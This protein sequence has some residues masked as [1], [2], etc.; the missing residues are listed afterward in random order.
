MS[1][2][3]NPEGAPQKGEDRK[4]DQPASAAV[5]SPIPDPV[6]PRRRI[7]RRQDPDYDADQ[8][9]YTLTSAEPGGIHGADSYATG[10]DPNPKFAEWQVSAL[11]LLAALGTIGFCVGYFAIG[12]HDR[13]G[14]PSNW[15]LGGGLAL[16]LT[17][18]G[19]G[20]ILWAKKL[21]PHEQAIQ[22]RE[23]FHSPEEDQLAAEETFLAG[24]EALQLH[25]PVLRRSLLA[26][27]GLLPIPAVIMLRDL[28][29]LPGLTL[30]Q[31]GW[32]AGQKL[33]Y[34]DTKQPVRLGDL[35]IGGIATVM[36]E[37]FTTPDDYPLA[38]TI[39]IRFGPNTIKSAKESAWGYADHV[40]YSKVCTHAGCPISLYE[41]QTHHLL[42]PCHQSTFQMDEDAK[43]IFGPA[44]RAL[45]QMKISVDEDGYFYCREPYTE[46]VGPS[47]WE[48]GSQ[49][50]SA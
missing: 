36:P 40:A 25:R 11:F 2:T 4:V 48:R 12:V 26:A 27:L 33:V 22:E 17:A 43:V 30:R 9:E 16:A 38:P 15:A 37:G 3:E 6:R 34:P 47:F 49:G 21:V 7:G 31:S 50:K 32:K 5:G 45:P 44:A 19:A 1:E 28:G 39:L 8:L 18:T 14:G 13:L 42:C 46:P 10:H 41:Q 24:A 23:P 20:M 35:D 29:P